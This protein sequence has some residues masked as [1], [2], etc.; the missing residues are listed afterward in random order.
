[1]TYCAQ[2]PRQHSHRHS[3]GV[4]KAPG[5]LLATGIGEEIAPR[6]EVGQ[7]ENFRRHLPSQ[8]HLSRK[9]CP[10][11]IILELTT[12]AILKYDDNDMNFM[13]QTFGVT[14]GGDGK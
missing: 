1:M 9:R 12:T 7:H 10:R 11:R 4:P 3:R 13:G 14:T 5:R 8:E 6:L 2:A